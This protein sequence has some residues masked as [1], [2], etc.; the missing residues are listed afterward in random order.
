LTDFDADVDITCEALGETKVPF[1]DS[2][3]LDEATLSGFIHVTGSAGFT[4]Q[5]RNRGVFDATMIIDYGMTGSNTQIVLTEDDGLAGQVV[6]N[7]ADDGGTWGSEV[8]VDIG[9][10]ELED[11]YSETAD[12]LGGGAI[13]VAPF[14]LHDEACDPLNGSSIDAYALDGWLTLDFYGP[15][16][17]EDTPVTIERRVFGQM[18]WTDVTSSFTYTLKNDGKNRT[19][20]ISGPN[21]PLLTACADY[22]ITPTADLKC[23]LYDNGSPPQV[24]SFLYELE[25]TLEGVC[26]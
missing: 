3:G 11:G 4:G 18:A 14:E 17:W 26:E 9:S 10:A 13:G 20:Q 2:T 12:E 7:N 25:V 23:D 19:L 8:R 5:V 6:I 24:D 16:M 1:G 21:D 22:R 15:V